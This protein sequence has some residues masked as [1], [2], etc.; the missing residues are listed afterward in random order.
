MSLSLYKH[1]NLFLQHS[2]NDISLK[3][4]VTPY[5]T[6]GSIKE[7]KILIPESLKNIICVF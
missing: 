1:P 6:K 3:R 2:D 7:V 5:I 4:V